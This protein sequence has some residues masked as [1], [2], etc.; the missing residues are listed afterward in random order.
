MLRPGLKLGIRINS[1][2]TFHILFYFSTRGYREKK[3]R[4]EVKERFEK[5]QPRKI[6]LFFECF[7]FCQNE[8]QNS[9]HS[10]GKKN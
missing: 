6:C 5:S 3:K 9:I 8:S 4:R 1:A 7:L 2:N 10:L